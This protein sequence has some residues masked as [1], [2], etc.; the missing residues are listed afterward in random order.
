MNPS[1][2]ASGSEGNKKSTVE[3]YKEI[4]FAKEGLSLLTCPKCGHFISGNDINI[5][6]TV[7]KCGH[8]HHVFGF[9]YDSSSSSLVPE[10]IIPQGIEE[11]KLRSELDIR[12]KW[13][14]TTSKGGRWFLTL[15]TFLWNI[16]LLPFVIAI[17]AS[18]EWGVL[19][20]LSFHLIVGMG[21][22][23]H[24]A[25]VYMNQTSINVTK[26]QIKIRT[27]PLWHP[28]SKKKEIDT[29]QLKQLYVTKYVQ[30]TS[31]GVPNYAFALYAILQSG[32]KVSLI[33]GMNKETQVFVEKAIEDYL[34]IKNVSV[35][36]EDG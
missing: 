15:F 23:W 14:E 35:P 19:L 4:D 12:L 9:A 18:G 7:A 2:P 34:E 30:S 5:E 31:N 3:A 6:K 20:F 11:F 26:H 22:L 25:T 1:D 24:M 8:C 16:I 29:S 27:T 33:R 21:L 13:L 10:Q 28:M 36:E 32:E 17:I